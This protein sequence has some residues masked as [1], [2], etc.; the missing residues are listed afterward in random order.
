[1]CL[2]VLRFLTSVDAHFDFPVVV[3]MMCCSV[4]YPG[5]RVVEFFKDVN[6]RDVCV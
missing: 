4:E 3:M 2:L 1:M 5:K 6:E